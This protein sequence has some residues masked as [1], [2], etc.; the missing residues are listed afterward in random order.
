[1]AARVSHRPSLGVGRGGTTDVTLHDPATS[2]ARHMQAGV[3][4]SQGVRLSSGFERVGSGASISSCQRRPAHA[5]TARWRRSSQPPL[6]PSPSSAPRSSPPT[7][8]LLHRATWRRS[9]HTSA[10][11]KACAAATATSAP[12]A[13]L[14]RTMRAV[15]SVESCSSR[16]GTVSS[17]AFGVKA[18][19]KARLPDLP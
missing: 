14:G 9:S 13:T 1:M 5:H 6:S 11:S 12:R 16:S 7:H 2:S 17:T 15:A 10:I 19:A 18:R 4:N 8:K 3:R